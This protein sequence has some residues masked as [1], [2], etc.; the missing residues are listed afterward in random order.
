MFNKN[1]SGPKTRGDN[2][3]PLLTNYAANPSSV[4]ARPNAAIIQP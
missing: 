3:K 4:E 2:P 1:P